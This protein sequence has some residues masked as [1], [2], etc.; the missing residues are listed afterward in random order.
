VV[1][2]PRLWALASRWYDDRLSLDWQRRTPEQRQA[3]F[4][5]VGLTGEFW[6]LTG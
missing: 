3:I 4:A 1:D 6:S 2:L 5:E